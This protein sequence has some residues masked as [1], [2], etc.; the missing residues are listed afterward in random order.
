M[1]P[2]KTATKPAPKAIRDP[3]SKIGKAWTF[4]KYRNGKLNL[5]KA[6][7]RFKTL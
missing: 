1:A 7:A 6:P 5:L 2:S 3:K 4:A